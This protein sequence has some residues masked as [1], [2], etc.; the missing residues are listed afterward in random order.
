MSYTIVKSLKIHQKPDG[1]WYLDICG[2]ENNVYPRTFETWTYPKDGEGKATK[3]DMEAFVIKEYVQGMMHGGENRYRMFVKELRLGLYTCEGW[4]RARRIYDLHDRA[5]MLAQK[6]WD[7]KTL[8]HGRFTCEETNWDRYNHLYAEYCKLIET[9]LVGHFHD[10]EKNGKDMRKYRLYLEDASGRH[11]LK[12]AHGYRYRYFVVGNSTQGAMEASATRAAELCEMH[13]ELHKEQIG[14]E[15]NE[16][17]PK[18]AELF[19]A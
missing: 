5:Y 15:T 12:S 8:A 19:A 13:K 17:K 16:K 14:I 18:Q 1:R 11:Y 2:A 3:A 6:L 9:G 7:G 10:W 4:T